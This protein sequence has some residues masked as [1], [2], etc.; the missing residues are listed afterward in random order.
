METNFSDETGSSS[1]DLLV[2]FL[3]GLADKIEAGSIDDTDLFQIAE[4]FI[5]FMCKKTIENEPKAPCV[6]ENMVTEKDFK[7]FL[8]LGW[9]V[10]TQLLKE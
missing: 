9:Y 3:R 4:F 1:D 5:S 6:S 7:K 8:M 2:P 10:Y